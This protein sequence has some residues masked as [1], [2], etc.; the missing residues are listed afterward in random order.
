MSGRRRLA[1]LAAAAALLLPGDSPVGAKPTSALRVAV[2]NPAFWTA[3]APTCED[4]GNP[5]WDFDLDVRAVSGTT[6]RLGIDHVVVGDVFEVSVTDPSGADAGTFSPGTG[7]YSQELV[8]D[9]P[10]AGRWQLHVVARGVTDRRFRMRA[11]L[12]R[13]AAAPRRRTVLAPNLQALPPHDI[14]FLMPLTNGSTDGAPEGVMSPGGRLACH[15]E[16]VVEDR[17]VRCLRMA[18]GV[19]NV[20]AGPMSLHLGPGAQGADRPL[21]QRLYFS[22]DTTEDRPA[23]GAVFHRTHAHYHHS[24]AIELTLL[25]VTDPAKGTL[26]PGATEHRKGFAHRDE[27]LREWRRFYPVFKKDGFGLLPGWGDYYEWDRPGN[28][29]DFGVNG[30]GRYVLRLTAD[31]V[32][33]IVETNDRDNTSYTYIE[34]TGTT[35]RLLE[36]GRGADPWDRC[37]ILIPLGAEPE[38]ARGQ[39][40]PKRPHTCPKDG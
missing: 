7:L 39:R 20:G 13:E 30:D 4:A 35:V 15:P 37:R 1:L 8:V 32:G 12:H 9:D 38:L 36:S 34:V 19:S 26:S 33:G 27:L 22:D 40:Q 28:Y 25:A 23:G 21:I 6:L 3:G 31:P 2:G 24:H 18:F 17:A 29:V 10:A 5:C 14:N 16:E 11:G